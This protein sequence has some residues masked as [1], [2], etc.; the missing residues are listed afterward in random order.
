MK[1]EDKAIEYGLDSLIEMSR[2]SGS[3]IEYLR[4]VHDSNP[5]LFKVILIGCI[6]EKSDK[7]IFR[8]EY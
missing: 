2:L 3:S 7:V 6:S 4:E 1:A 5:Q 8:A